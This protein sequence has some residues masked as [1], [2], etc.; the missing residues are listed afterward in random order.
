MVIKKKAKLGEQRY[1]SKGFI[2]YDATRRGV[3]F[4]EWTD[5]G[6]CDLATALQACLKRH[7]VITNWEKRNGDQTWLLTELELLP[8]R[9]WVETEP[10]DLRWGLLDSHGMPIDQ[11]R[12][13][14]LPKMR[15]AQLD[16]MVDTSH[17]VARALRA[18]LSG[19]DGPSLRVELWYG[20]NEM[21]ACIL[22]VVD[23][24]LCDLGAA[25]QAE[26]I[27]RLGGV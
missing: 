19:P 13:L 1:R 6:L 3:N 15:G 4:L 26:L 12:A 14:A 20:L 22:H 9:V 8:V 18:H 10:N 17:Q 21:G 7:A 5:K 16:D 25:D 24:L 2:V 27:L 11:E 23:P